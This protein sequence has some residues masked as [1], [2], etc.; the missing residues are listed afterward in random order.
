MGYELNSAH[1][2]KTGWNILS[3]STTAAN[4]IMRTDIRV[5]SLLLYDVMRCGPIIPHVWQ[6]SCFIA[7][8]KKIDY[9]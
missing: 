5:F 9:S 2:F 8:K 1:E 3:L 7:V 6:K 4:A